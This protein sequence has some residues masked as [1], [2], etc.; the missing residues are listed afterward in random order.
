MPPY[1]DHLV[2]GISSQLR[3]E[4]KGLDEIVFTSDNDY[5]SSGLKVISLIRMG[6]IATVPTSAIYGRLG[7]V[8][9]FRLARLLENF[10][11][12]INRT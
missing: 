2:A 7:S 4:V 5:P 8:S 3:H 1:G 12:A 6:M 10:I 9:P 11:A